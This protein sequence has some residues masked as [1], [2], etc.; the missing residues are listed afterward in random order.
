M[1]FS[2]QGGSD[3]AVAAIKGT[4]FGKF[5]EARVVDG[6]TSMPQFDLASGA[7]I[8]DLGTRAYPAGTIFVRC[9]N[10]GDLPGTSCIAAV[11]A[12]GCVFLAPDNGLLT[13]VAA[14]PGFDAVYRVASQS[15]FARPLK[16]ASADWVLPTAAALLA[17]GTTPEE[18]GPRVA[19]ITK[20]D[21]PE[22]RR[23]GE[24]VMGSVVFVD[25][26]G[27]CL[28]NIPESLMRDLGAGKADR[29][30]VSWRGGDATM[31]VG[32]AYGDVPEGDPIALLNGSSPLQL[33][34]NMDSFAGV[35]GVTAGRP[36][37]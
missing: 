8:L 14:D 4:I 15:L 11:S 16:T 7:Y 25:R 24:T 23:A 20:L 35:C 3:Y 36:P 19:G 10:P 29:V 22:A 27:N 37:R 34:V 26:F 33:S 18:L 2:D 28:T 32:S 13:R 31:I 5:P 6:E 12:R 1:L 21:I 17:S 9:E 30:V